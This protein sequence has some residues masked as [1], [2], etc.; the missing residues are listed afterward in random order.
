MTAASAP[1][2]PI[3]ASATVVSIH[4]PHYLPWLGLVAKIACSDVF[5]YLD[6][7]QFEK[8]G[9]QNRQRYSTDQGLKFLSLPVQQ[10]GVV[11]GQKEIREVRLA[12]P[13]AP[14]KHWKTLSQR[15]GKRP[16]WPR[17][18]PRL[19]AILLASH[20]KLISFCLATTALTLEVFQVEP[21]IVF[22]S[23]LSVEGQK[24]DR[25]INLVKAVNATH[26]LS[27]AGA[28]EYLDPA[29]FER[30]ELGLTFQEFNDPVYAQSTRQPFTPGAFALEW[31]IEDP[32]NAA[33]AFHE[34]LR[35]NANQPPRCVSAARH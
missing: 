4:Q 5:V 35:R 2:A 16:G 1:Q 10:Q 6:N 17:L 12:D 25:V 28:R 14:L 21:K 9:W 26:Y 33:A 34:H 23:E 7:V 29:P 31:Y 19:E 30:N 32:E 27:G 8:N 22:A 18:A 3:P 20:E 15:Y 13:R 24:S 11:S